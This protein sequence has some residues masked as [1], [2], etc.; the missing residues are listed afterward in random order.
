[1][2]GQTTSG[3]ITI[4]RAYLGNHVTS[5]A[6]TWSLV[7][8]AGALGEG[9]HGQL[10]LIADITDGAVSGVL[11]ASAGGPMNAILG[12]PASSVWTKSIPFPENETGWTHIWKYNSRI[13]ALGV[14]C[15][16]WSCPDNDISSW[17]HVGTYPP[18]T[19]NRTSTANTDTIPAI[20]GDSLYYLGATSGNGWQVPVRVRHLDL[21]TEFGLPSISGIANTPQYIRIA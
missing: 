16:I 6:I 17:S 18:G 3:N 10:R 8:L 4:P 14:T 9:G 15:K 13:Y 2:I 5:G 19:F 11:V 1:M 20:L 12:V 21:S 7:D